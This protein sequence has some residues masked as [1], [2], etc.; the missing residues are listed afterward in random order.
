MPNHVTNIV[1]INAVPERVNEILASIQND[2]T[3]IGSIDFNKLLPMPESL[4][5]ESGSTT[6][7]CINLYLTS[8]NPLVD[9]F[10]ENKVSGNEY[11]R[12]INLFNAG[13]SKLY[14]YHGDVPLADVKKKMES[15]LKY[16]ENFKSA[17]DI[18]A[19]AKTALDNI[20]RYGHKDW[21]DWCC[22]NWGTK[23]SAY[24]FGDYKQG[25]NTITFLTAW[26]APHTIIEL[27]SEKFPEAEFTHSWADEGIGSN[28]G[29]RVY[30][31]GEIVDWDI[32]D[33]YSVEAYEMAADIMGESLESRGLY[34][35][36][37]GKTYEYRE[38]ENED[39][40]EI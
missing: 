40:M 26:A 5:I 25:D 37:D 18:F 21:Y 38:E 8:I 34:I 29:S 6:N 12:I 36:D 4:D 14:P 10:G 1:K 20:E 24:A 3:G 28:V 31:G 16:S 35:T 23:W 30:K 13:D 19:L 39:D 11:V 9:Y 33:N 27:L 15:L 7:D 32:P 22:N 2:E 17:D